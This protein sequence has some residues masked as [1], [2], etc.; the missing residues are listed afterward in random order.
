MRK[1]V[2]V[3]LFSGLVAGCGGG[4]GDDGGSLQQPATLAI[5]AG[6]QNDVAS[7]SATA[8]T[9]ASALASGAAGNLG[10]EIAAS[11]SRR[12]ALALTDSRR[13]GFAARVLASETETMSCPRG[14]SM[15]ITGTDANGNEEPDAGD[16]LSM[17]FSNC[18]SDVDE[19]VDGTLSMAFTSVTQNSS[20]V[21]ISGTMTMDLSTVDGDEQTTV[22]GEVTMH[23]ASLSPSR[24]QLDLAVTGSALRASVRTA[25]RSETIAYESGFAISMIGDV[26]GSGSY[27]VDGDITSS[28]LA[29]RISIDTIQPFVQFADADYPSSGAM[30][31][32]GSGGS[33]LH[34]TAL[35]GAQVLLELD[36]DGN[37]N[38]ESSKTFTWEALLRD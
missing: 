28:M 34:L 33:Q 11:T 37:G 30:R 20:G 31:V 32:L 36:T 16:S 14:G 29:G 19:S 9:G 21:S 35:S 17:V 3:A 5:H 27:T 18:R 12:I 15:T 24:A 38:Y 7:T 26:G 4:G 2:W 25:T 1:Y 10:V 22:K 23:L 13:R 6:N 8:V